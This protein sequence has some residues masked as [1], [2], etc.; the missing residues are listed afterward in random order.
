MMDFEALNDFD[1]AALGRDERNTRPAP[2]RRPLATV[3]MRVARR[4]WGEWV[5]RFADNGERAR[6]RPTHTP[7]KVTKWQRH[8]T[9]PLSEASDASRPMHL[10]RRWEVPSS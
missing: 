8:R 3:S 1:V 5:E 4:G 7:A 10:Q 9:R 6:S 2:A